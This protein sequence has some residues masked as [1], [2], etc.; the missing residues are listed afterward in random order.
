M[1]C[2]GY[3]QQKVNLGKVALRVAKLVA[4]LPAHDAA[5][6]RDSIIEQEALK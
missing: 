3:P 4:A 2:C 6:G 5:I 1:I